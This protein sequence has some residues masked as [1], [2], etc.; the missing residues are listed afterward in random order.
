MA[1]QPKRARTGGLVLAPVGA[2]PLSAPLAYTGAFLSGLLYFLAFG[3]ID[4]WPLTWIAWVPLVVAMHRQ[5]TRRATLLGWLSGVT[6]NVTGF[7]WLQKFLQTFSGFP[8]PICFFFVLVVCAYQGG[9]MALLGWLYGRAS[10]R[11]WPAP[12]VFA[13][14]F[15]ASELVY[16]LLFPCITRRRFTKSLR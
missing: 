2:L 4:V 11:G 3:G 13:A 1:A 7:F 16:P 6:M 8:A 10:A 14:A 12:L 9:R 5:P 15:V